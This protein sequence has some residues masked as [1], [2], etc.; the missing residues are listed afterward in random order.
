MIIGNL[1]ASNTIRG[2]N[3][4]QVRSISF[5]NPSS[6]HRVWRSGVERTGTITPI[7]G[8]TTTWQILN[9]RTRAVVASGSGVS[10]THTF[11]FA[12]MEDCN[13]Y[14][15]LVVCTNGVKTFR[16]IF[17]GEFTCLP[18]VPVSY[19]I[20]WNTSGDKAMGWTN[21]AGTKILATGNLTRLNPYWLK[22][23]DPTQPVHIVLKDLNISTATNII[24]FGTT[25]F[26]NVIIDGCTE[27]DVQYGGYA[28]KTT[29]A[30]SQIF[31]LLGA[32]PNDNTKTSA[33]V[34]ICGLDCNGNNIVVSVSFNRIRQSNLQ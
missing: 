3:S 26:K 17:P 24:S 31:Q 21:R 2:G 22:S 20:T 25:A 33:N 23:D 8:Y 1:I 5:T 6:I 9:H 15:L 30:A 4:P 19:D 11:T 7:T 32:E 16:K 29:G 27:E 34:I 28:E 13:V 18:P 12:S 14:D 10:V